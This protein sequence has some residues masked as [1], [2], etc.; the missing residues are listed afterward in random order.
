MVDPADDREGA[1]SGSL[2]PHEDLAVSASEISESD[3]A[4]F[5][6]S[7]EALHLRRLLADQVLLAALQAQGLQG[8]DWDRFAEVLARYG[9]QVIRAWVRSGEIFWQCRRRG[10]GH[11][12]PPRDERPWGADE[13][14]ELALETVAIAV[15]KYR[16]TV[17]AVNRWS[18]EGGATL[19][20]FFIGQCLIRFANVY[21]AWLRETRPGP[22]SGWG[23]PPCAPLEQLDD[24]TMRWN[25]RTQGE[26]GD[27]VQAVMTK[28]EVERGLAGVDARTGTALRCSTEGYDYKEIGAMLGVSAKAVDGLLARHRRRLRETGGAA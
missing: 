15:G 17:L 13:A 18:P 21:R 22:G 2:E 27:P 1:R 9:Y 12:E 16:D 10:W 7:E 6:P 20:T 19:K 4:G 26:H 11:L 28:L 3:L 5:E 25:L 24:P 23:G 8:R 14:D